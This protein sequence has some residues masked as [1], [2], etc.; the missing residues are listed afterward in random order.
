MPANLENSAVATGL[1]KVSPIPKKGNVKQCSNY[2]TVALISHA[3]VKCS[4]FSKQGFNST[5]TVNFQ[6]FKLDLEKAEEPKIKFPTFAGSSKSKRVLEKH[7]F[8][9][10]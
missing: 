5:R 2:H 1:E 8:L 10:Y 6:M 4:K 9:L 3:S 7:L